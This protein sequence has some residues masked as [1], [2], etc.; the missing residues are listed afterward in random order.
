MFM[1]RVWH[2]RHV[3][4][5]HMVTHTWYHLSPHFPLLSGVAS[6]SLMVGL[7][8]HYTARYISRYTT[9]YTTRYPTWWYTHHTT[10]TT[11]PIN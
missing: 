1:H 6:P 11:H 10:H 5:A 2:T 9:R 8:A 3:R 4:N 7:T